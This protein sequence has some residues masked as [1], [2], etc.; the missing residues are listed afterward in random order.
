MTKKE[1]IGCL[2]GKDT[3]ALF[4]HADAA[5][6]KYCGDEV[7]IRGIIEFSNY[8]KRDCLYC[9]LRRSN[10]KLKRY[11]MSPEEIA[12]T[13]ENARALNYKTIVLQSGEDEQYSIKDL[14]KIIARIKKNIGCA[15]TV[16]IGEK[17]REDYKALR[18]AGADR[19]LLKFETSDK[20]LFQKLKPD[21]SYEERLACLD[22]LRRLGFQ[23]G[24]GSMV[25]LPGQTDGILAGDIMLMKRFDL[26]M[27]GIGPFIPHHDTPLAGAKRGTVT[28]TLKMI[29]LARI[30]TKNAHIPATTALGTIDPAGRQKGLKCGANV[31][32]PN[33]TPKKYRKLYSIY[34]DKICISEEPGD[35]GRCVERMVVSVGRELGK[36]PGHSLKM[37]RAK[38]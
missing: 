4:A 5:R 30:A 12:D 32:M 33:L 23:V 38:R 29:A 17:S 16:S 21:S 36:G 18:D 28:K 14:A 26:D 35:C 27:I 25:G 2:Q 11:R 3:D 37:K 15:I 6:R 10:A 24:S 9:G 8:C 34:P 1:I 19:Y 7:H 20:K 13:A 31:I 22:T